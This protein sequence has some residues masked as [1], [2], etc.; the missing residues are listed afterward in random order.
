MAVDF[1]QTG[2]E[3]EVIL[4]LTVGGT[5]RPAAGRGEDFG[6]SRSP[7]AFAALSPSPRG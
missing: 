2:D 1:L 5:A 3:G 4:V 7:D 6:L